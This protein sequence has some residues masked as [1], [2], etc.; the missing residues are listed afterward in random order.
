[1]MLRYKL[2]KTHLCSA[3]CKALADSTAILWMVSQLVCSN[4]VS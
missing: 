2:K 4:S 1:M 3:D